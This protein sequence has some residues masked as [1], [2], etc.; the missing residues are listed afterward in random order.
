[1]LDQKASDVQNA[2]TNVLGEI[3]LDAIIIFFVAILVA[4]FV[5][6]FCVAIVI[7]LVRALARLLS[8]APTKGEKTLN[9]QRTE[10]YLS[11][12]LALL[13]GTI[14]AVFLFAAWQ[15]VNPQAAPLAIVSASTFFVVVAGATLAPM[16][17]DVMSG[18]LIIIERWYNVGDYVSLIP[19]GNASGIVERMTLSYTILRDINGEVIW[20]HNQNI[21]GARVLSKGY[22]TFTIELFV[23]DPAEGKKL[24]EQASAMLPSGSTM[25]R[26]KLAITETQEINSKLWQITAQCQTAPMREWLIEDFA[27]EA[28]KELDEDAKKQCIVHGPM[29]RYSDPDAERRF[30][31]S[32]QLKNNTAKL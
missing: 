31:K 24:I 5:S 20:V 23:N 14:F 29:I 15:V 18:A 21:Q 3:N 16:F 1:M 9:A 7:K 32:M 27:A 17:R 26:K 8:R 30:T 4:Y 2:I 19:L 6:K 25:M 11:V 28:I 13:R 22:R 12:S 10:T